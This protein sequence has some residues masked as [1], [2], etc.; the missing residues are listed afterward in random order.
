MMGLKAKL[1]RVWALVTKE[2]RQVFR[3]PRLARLIFVA[4]IIQLV[5][6]GYAVTTDIDDTATFVVDHSRTRDSRELVEDLETT[7]HR[8]GHFGRQR[9]LQWLHQRRQAIEKAES[10]LAVEVIFICRPST[11]TKGVRIMMPPW[12]DGGSRR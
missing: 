8:G 7:G 5:V 10:Q 2:F 4:P 11:R 3:D 6:F 9:V 1:E 12:P